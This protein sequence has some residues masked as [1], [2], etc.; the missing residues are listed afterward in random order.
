VL[1]EGPRHAGIADLP[2]LLAAHERRPL[3][4]LNDSRVVPARVHA[5]RLGA[6]EAERKFELLICDP[7]AAR[8]GALVRA[9]VRGAKRLRVGDR[10]GFG[11]VVLGYLGPDP[12]DTRARRFELLEGELL[13]VLEQTGEL[14]LPPYVARPE[15]PSAHDRERYQTVFA[16]DRGSVAAPTAGLHLDAELLAAID[17][18]FVTLHVGPGT[19]LPMDVADVREHRVGAER[20]TIP[21]A[22][23]DAIADARAQ[24]RPI[25]AVGTTVTRTLESVAAANQ[26][27][28]VAGSGATELVIGPEHR[29]RCVDMLLTNFHLPRSSLLMLVCSLAGRERVLAGYREALR[30]GYRFYSYGDC[31][32]VDRRDGP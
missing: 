26:G 3:V 8:P 31:M 17:H 14:P 30:A 11:A 24:G 2:A 13:E 9:W 25:L 23:A 29:F 18:A 6:G 21:Q 7:A 12:I 10:L 22:S 19:F 28:I 20:F 4:V 1:L 16:R 15:G 32:L 5:R 27:A